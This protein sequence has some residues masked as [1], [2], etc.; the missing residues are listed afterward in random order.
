MRRSRID[1]SPRSCSINGVVSSAPFG[2]NSK[3][4]PCS[5]RVF[6][7]PP[8]SASF[9]R[10]RTSIP[11]F[12]SQ[13]AAHSPEMPAPTMTTGRVPSRDGRRGLSDILLSGI[14]Q[15]QI[16]EAPDEFRIVVQRRHHLELLDA[17]PAG[18]EAGFHIDFV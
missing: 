16:R 13:C 17:E 14:F 1:S 12:F 15:D 5:R 6:I 2:P 4:H 10:T 11:A 3:S 7:A 8:A 9:S 18:F